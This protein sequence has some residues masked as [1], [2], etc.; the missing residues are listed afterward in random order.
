MTLTPPPLTLTHG[1][2]V[3]DLKKL[4]V[5][6]FYIAVSLSDIVQN[7]LKHIQQ[8][9]FKKVLDIFIIFFYDH[10]EPRKPV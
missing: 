3:K 1:R 7:F 6:T 2:Q 9:Y 4:S 5:L 8:A 10:P